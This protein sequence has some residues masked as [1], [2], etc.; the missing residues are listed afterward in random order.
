MRVCI[1]AE[2]ASY[3]FGGEAVLPLHYF[4]GLRA[5][6]VEAWLVVHG[7]TRNELEDVFASDSS[8]LRFISDA[9]FHKLLNRLSGFLP[10]RI[11]GATLGLLSQLIT[12]YLAR[13]IVRELIAGESIDVVHQPIPVSPR[14]PSVMTALGVPVVIGPMNGGMEYPA[15]F[16]NAESA[17]SRVAISLGRQFSNFFNSLL[18]G[19]KRADILLVANERTR[20]A[21]PAGVRGQVIELVENAVHLKTWSSIPNAAQTHVKPRFVFI[22][23]LVDWKALDIVIE[24]LGLVPDAELTIIGD[25]PMRESWR[26]ATENLGVSDRVTFTGWLPQIECAPHL[27]AALALVL[28]SL[29]ECGGA[30]VLEAMASGTPVIA[31]RWGGPA[32]YLDNSCGSLIE[33]SSREAMVQGFAAAMSKLV[34][35]PQLRDQLGANGRQRVEQSFD[36]DKKIDRMLAIYREAQRPPLLLRP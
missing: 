6:G 18:P 34:R 9:W 36:W 30:V 20:L 10:H 24:A 19:K 26:Q 3:K 28:P 16:R 17:F 5:R 33:P 13:K 7:R 25:G 35:E 11:S 8:R 14:F 1:V 22:G 4:A 29:Y 32:D 27:H 31:T 12:Q 23:R 21:L 2:H 15:A